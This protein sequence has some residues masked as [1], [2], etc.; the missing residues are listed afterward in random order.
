MKQTEKPKY[1]IFQCLGF[2]LSYSWRY[3]RSAIWCLLGAIFIPLISGLAELFATPAILHQLEIG[4]PVTQL[5]L[6]IGVF[7]LVWMVAAGM[8]SANFEF[9]SATSRDI[10]HHISMD[11]ERKACTTSYPNS[12]DPKLTQMLSRANKALTYWRSGV[13]GMFYNGS[14]LVGVILSF[15]V[16][17]Y[18]LTRMHWVLPTVVIVTSVIDLVVNHRVNKWSYQHRGEE[19]EALKKVNYVQSQVE[20][21]PVA[22]DIR[23]FGLRGW[24]DRIYENSKV[25][26]YNY[27]QRRE[28]N[29][30]KG[31]LV[32]MLLQILRN[33]ISYAFLIYLAV[34]KQLPASEIVLYFSA[35][36]GLAEWIKNI[37]DV[38]SALHQNSLEVSILREYLN[39]PEPFRFAGGKP[40]PK[41]EGYELTLE[42]V[43]FRYPGAEENLFE[44]LNLIIR[45]GEKVAVVGLNGAGK[46]TLV[47][48]L[49][50]FYDPDE[51][52]VLLNGQDI[53]EFNRQEYYE[54][55]SAVFQDT[56][57]LEVTI[58]QEVA[59]TPENIDTDRLNTCIEKAGLSGMVEKLPQGL[60]THIGRKAF[61]DGVLFSGGQ[62]QRLMLARALY[63]DGPIL[64]LDEPTAALDPLAEHDIYMK[65][66]EMTAGKTSVFIS[67]RLASTRF[68]D[69]IIFLAEGKIA[70]EGT[71]KELLKKNGGYAELFQIQSRYY[72]EGG[73]KNGEK[74]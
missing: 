65:Y 35:V 38:A 31:N 22:K 63:K 66:N 5:L 62:T 72:Q 37:L 4:A 70:E 11:L 40:V 7:T 36:S 27:Y 68:C 3:R 69:R 57:Q 21:I 49:C 58:A 59:Q 53:R 29:A 19:G 50:G 16:Y 41:A 6:V 42:N 32:N 39:L 45:P 14:K 17:V 30:L 47:R 9:F 55:F 8:N 12:H 15:L 2:V 24:L 74:G 34:D 20:S 26:L 56:S 54:L 61:D 64:V 33:G 60:Q 13:G 51:G 67:H 44:N 71:H 73:A 43:T 10:M 25:L 52:R 23:I 28:K 18:L 48:L 1:N 46:T